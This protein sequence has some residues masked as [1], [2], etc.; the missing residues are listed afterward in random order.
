MPPGW[1][2][3]AILEFRRYLSLQVVATQPIP[4]FSRQVDEVWHTCV[5]FTRLYADLCRTCFGYFVHHE[6]AD[7]EAPGSVTWS[8]FADIYREFYGEPGRLW[9]MDRDA[10]DLFPRSNERKR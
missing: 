9:T 6:P 4:M 7:E 5:L 1:V 10:G 3:E 2:D 8:D